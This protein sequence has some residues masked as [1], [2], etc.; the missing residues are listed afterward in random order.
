MKIQTQ[1]RLTVAAI[2]ISCVAIGIVLYLSES[3]IGTSI[4]T[5]AT[6][7]ATLFA[8]YTAWLAKG[9]A[10][11]AQTTQ[12]AAQGA[13]E[14]SQQFQ[15]RQSARLERLFAEVIRE[16]A[17]V[18]FDLADAFDEEPSDQ[19][20]L[21]AERVMQKSRMRLKLEQERFDRDWTWLSKKLSGRRI[22]PDQPGPS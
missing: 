22:D 13:I 9:T 14:A 21:D 17:P 15:E 19:D 18:E 5:A 2:L 10:A 16:E 4:A 1:A 20:L 7:G 8:A 3:D 6:L 11:E 12:L